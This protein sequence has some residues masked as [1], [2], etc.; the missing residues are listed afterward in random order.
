[1][2]ARGPDVA[3]ATLRISD[4][5]V[6]SAALTCLLVYIADLGVE[7]FLEF[8]R[9]LLWLFPHSTVQAPRASRG[10]GGTSP[11]CSL[12]IPSLDEYVFDLE[13]YR[14]ADD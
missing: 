7:I 8:S 12:C 5:C 6:I 10:F 11:G 3:P 1:M 2:A 9:M 4:G 13:N 14:P